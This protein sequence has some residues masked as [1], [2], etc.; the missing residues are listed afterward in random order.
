MIAALLG[1]SALLAGPPTT[2]TAPA[3]TPAPSPTPAAAGLVV[4]EPG[5]RFPESYAGAEIVHVFKV[6]N[7]GAAPVRVVEFL[8]NTAPTLVDPLPG[9]IPPGGR[10]EVTVRQGT[11][12]RLGLVNYRYLLKTDD[13]LPDR[14]LSLGGFLQSAYEPDQPI[15]QGD[16]GPG[17]TL[18]LPIACREVERFEILEVTDAPA[19]LR[20]DGSARNADGPVLRAT[21]A[22]DAPLGLHNGTLVVR[23]NVAAQPLVAVPFRLVVFAD[24]APEDLPVDLGAI[25]AGAP[26]EKRTRLRSR[27]R[28]AFEVAAVEGA[29]DGITVEPAACP[30]PADS[31]RALVFKGTGPAAT[32]PMSG[33]VRVKLARGRDLWVPYSGVVVRADAPV[34]D[35]ARTVTAPNFGSPPGALPFPKPTPPPVPPPVTGKPGE[36]VARLTW[37]AGQEEQAYGYLIYRADKPEGPFRRVNARIVPVSDAPPPHKYTYEDKDVEAGRSYYYYLESISK[38]GVKDRLSGVVTKVIPPA[39]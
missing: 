12:G 30:E 27:S 17:G 25:R 29:P 37:N 11:L 19:F 8:P 7:D 3:A 26:F 10:A 22:E 35:P 1:A 32:G 4:E 5:A 28:Q 34:A 39:P 20:F 16:V 18:E 33:A 21:V 36:K 23:T 15:L 14:R 13:G 38:G 31:C 9:P 24:V 6:R 2:P